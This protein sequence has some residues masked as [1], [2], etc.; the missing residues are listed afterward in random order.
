MEYIISILTPRGVHLYGDSSMSFVTGC[1]D[2]SD[3][4]SIMKQLNS[5]KIGE[6]LFNSVDEAAAAFTSIEHRRTL[7]SNPR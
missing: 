6:L 7:V 2:I 4:G 3:P 5:E 1:V